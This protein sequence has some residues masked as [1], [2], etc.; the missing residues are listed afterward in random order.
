MEDL[1]SLVFHKLGDRPGFQLAQLRF[2]EM[3]EENLAYR[4][5]M[6]YNCFT[7]KEKGV[8]IRLRVNHAW[9]F[10]ATDQLDKNSV[11]DTAEIAWKVAKAS[12]MVRREE[13]IELAPEPI[14]K[15]KYSIPIDKD[16]FDIDL[17]D[18]LELI[19]DANT[20][21]MESSDFIKMAE[22]RL[23]FRDQTIKFYSSEG[24]NIEQRLMFSGAQ[25]YAVAVEGADTQTRNLQDYQSKGWEFIEEYDPINK[26]KQVGN[27]ATV[28]VTEAETAPSGKSTLILEPYQLGLTIHE[29]CG[30]PAELDRVLGYEADFAGTSWLTLD[31]LNELR[32]GNEMINITQDPSMPGVLGHF[33]Y[34]DEGVKSRAVPIIKNGKFVGYETDREHAAIIGMKRSSGNSKADRFTHVP[35]IRM[36]NLYLEADPDGYKNVEEMIADTKDGVYGLNWKSHSIDDKRLNFQFATQIGYKIE[37]GEITKPLK[38]LTYQ[39]ITPEFWGATSGLTRNSKIYGLPFCGKGS[40]GMQVGY[41]SHGGPWGRFEDISINMG[42]KQ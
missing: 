22:S 33:K 23:R 6:P 35:I 42:F 25:L 8:G 27:E 16:P 24:D 5:G 34:D 15:D 18:K 2:V 12:A 1:A 4:N 28:L 39:A 10:A 13:P 30:H 17:E 21:I 20:A 31:K 29:S 32:Y 40:P 7:I 11:L 36:N 37:D 9:G 38:N 19:K 3:R 41:V 26:G 14:Y